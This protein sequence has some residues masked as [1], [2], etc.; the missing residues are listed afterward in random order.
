MAASD[1][2]QLIE[3]ARNLYFKWLVV[4]TIAVFV[5]VLLEE[6]DALLL[7]LLS[8]GRIRQRVPLKVLLPPHR[9]A[10]CAK[11]ISRVGWLILMAGVLGEGVFEVKV[12]QEDSRLQ[13][14]TT[15]RLEAA[16][17]EIVRLS[18]VSAQA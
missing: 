9:I 6:S 11:R 8:K 5:G 18:G 3:A 17:N 7:W 1:S 12:S 14:A 15:T 10:K 2:V 16:S 4:S 13:L